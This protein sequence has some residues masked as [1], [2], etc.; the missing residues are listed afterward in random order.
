MISINRRRFL[1]LLI[2]GATVF[3]A[4]TCG[5]AIGSKTAHAATN[6]TT[7]LQKVGSSSFAC[8]TVAGTSRQIGIA[9]GK[10]FRREI[11]EGINRRGK[12]F[13][14]L[15][16]YATGKGKAHL[17][18][19][20]Q[21]ARAYA[22]K[23]VDELEGWAE[24]SGIPFLDL[25]ILNCNNELDTRLEE[26][27]RPPGDCSTVALKDGGKLF[28]AHNEDGTG[29]YSDLMWVLHAIPDDSPS[30]ICLSYPGFMEGNAPAVNSCGIAITTNYIG[31]REVRDGIPRY[32]ISRM[33]MAARTADEAIAIACHPER[34]YGYHHIVASLEEGRAWAVEVTPS[35]AEK[36]EI[37][38]LYLHTNHLI[39]D[40]LKN[41]PQFDKYNALSSIPR[42][43]SLQ[44]L[45]G[46]RKDLS[47]IGKDDIV[48]TLSS[49]EGRPY[50]LCRHPEGEAEGATVG[51][52]FF[53][54]PSK[55]FQME[56]YKNNPC[57]GKKKIYRPVG[58]ES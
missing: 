19:M 6:G 9:I 44:K 29:K 58:T 4:V 50:S 53:E 40:N 11:Q 43:N 34:A 54:G 5:G 10:T 15:K 46:S 45:L 32:F 56:L 14:H 7:S 16:E 17:D 26:D 51:M 36:R 47:S 23:V 55:S 3:G 18:A 20:L 35:Q 22:P 2:S 42:F 12:W 21:K 28:I 57:G 49:H 52:A 37:E 41:T 13:S 30:F 1:K 48:K 25:L 24:G 38:G 31:T 27:K 8:L 39:F 33:M